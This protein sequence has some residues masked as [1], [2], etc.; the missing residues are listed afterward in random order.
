MHAADPAVHGGTWAESRWRV[1]VPSLRR[2]ADYGGPCK[3]D[4]YALALKL[5][6]GEDVSVRVLEPRDLVAV[7][8]RPDS[9]CVLLHPFVAFKAD[10]F[11]GKEGD[12]LFDVRNLPSEDRGG[13]RFK[14][15]RLLAD[16]HRIAAAKDS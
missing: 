16:D 12:G 10:A 15:L 13:D 8:T 1:L 14:L 7:R 9:E 4:R 6:Q 3:A 11:F 2:S 5:S